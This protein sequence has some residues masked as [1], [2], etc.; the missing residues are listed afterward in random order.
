LISV[1]NPEAVLAESVKDRLLRCL[2]T[3]RGNG[4]WLLLCAPLVLAA[5]IDLPPKAIVDAKSIQEAVEFQNALDA[6]SDSPPPEGKSWFEIVRGKRAVVITAPHATKPLREGTYRFADGTGTAALAITLQRLTDATVIY[7][8]YFSPSDP[9]FYDDN[10]F[11]AALKGIIEEVKPAIV[12]DL[13]GSA[14]ARPYDVDIGTMDGM[15]L[16]GREELLAKLLLALRAEGIQNLSYNYFPAS[17]NQTITKFA[18]A[19]SVP[20]IQLE[21]SATLLTPNGGDLNEHRFAQIAQA[22]TRYI[23]TTVPAES[24]KRP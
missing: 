24:E 18:H 4:I 21:I 11:K 2:R 19:N 5:A 15:S 3:S 8:T 7:T 6:T 20:G 14:A 23:E 10:A 22:L 17:K 12:L 16:L 1:V 13:H 9:N